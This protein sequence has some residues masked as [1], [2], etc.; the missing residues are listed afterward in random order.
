MREC[1]CSVGKTRQPRV[2]A[3]Y[4]EKAWRL[5]TIIYGMPARDDASTSLWGLERFAADRRT[6]VLAHSVTCYS[7]SLKACG[8][9]VAAFY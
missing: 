1:K 9:A 7:C 3:K 4:E 2:A 8:W 5:A 6:N